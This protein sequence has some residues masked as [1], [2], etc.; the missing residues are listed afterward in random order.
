MGTD[1]DGRSRPSSL[2][3]LRGSFGNDIGALED[4]AVIAFEVG[5]LHFHLI[6]ILLELLPNPLSALF[7]G[8]AVHDTRTI[9]ALGST[10][11]I[12]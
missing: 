7:V 9:A 10:E 12:G 6:T 2:L 5:F 4:S 3:C 11:Q 8:L 1:E